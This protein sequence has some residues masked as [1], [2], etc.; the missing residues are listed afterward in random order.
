MR[1]GKKMEEKQN[2]SGNSDRNPAGDPGESLH[3][4]LQELIGL[5]RQLYEVVKA[6]HEAI[7]QADTKAT[8]EAV[9]NKEALIHWI[10][11][12]ELNRQAVIRGMPR[13]THHD[14]GREPSLREIIASLQGR[15]NELADRLQSDLQTLVVLV[16]RI[17]NQNR[18][19]GELV[20]RSL[21]HINNMKSNIFGETTHQGKTYNQ[22]GQKNQ[23][24]SNAHGPRLIS[25]EV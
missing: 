18:L 20:N 21:G 5:H 10:H 11:R 3:E 19:N 24:A 16:E 23:A 13:G 4:S 17:R 22:N 2:P 7:T 9:A 14:S 12:E 25:K 1:A 15:N 6:E 8:Y